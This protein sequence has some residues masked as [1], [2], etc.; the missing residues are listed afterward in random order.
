MCVCVCV[1]VCV[2]KRN[3]MWIL[4]Q[5]LKKSYHILKMPFMWGKG[6]YTLLTL[7]SQECNLLNTD[8]H[9]FK[10]KCRNL[11]SDTEISLTKNLIQLPMYMREVRGYRKPSASSVKESTKSSSIWSPKSLPRYFFLTNIVSRTGSW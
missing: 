6:T 3:C 9:T 10:I 4:F 7:E 5:F 8:I 1:C 11:R 2:F